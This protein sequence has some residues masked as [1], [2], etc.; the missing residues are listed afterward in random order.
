MLCCAAGFLLTCPAHCPPLPLQVFPNV[1]AVLSEQQAIDLQLA[2]SA[3]T[4]EGQAVLNRL[5]N[6]VVQPRNDR[7]VFAA[8]ATS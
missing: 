3:A 6:R 1:R 8:C 4:I 7:N 2:L 5:N